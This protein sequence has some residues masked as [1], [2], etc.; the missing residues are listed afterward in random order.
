M[1]HIEQFE[2]IFKL[3]RDLLMAYTIEYNH[4][5]ISPPQ[6]VEYYSNVGYRGGPG[7]CPLPGF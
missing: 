2:L 6:I 5:D 1:N 4:I 7:T 3:E